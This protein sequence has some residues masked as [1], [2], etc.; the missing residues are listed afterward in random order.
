[1]YISIENVKHKLEYI[2]YPNYRRSESFYVVHCRNK[3][4]D[5]IKK[6]KH[7]PECGEDLTCAHD[8][9]I[10]ATDEYGNDYKICMLCGLRL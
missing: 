9:P 1:M 3:E 8:K 2:K 7:C 5:V 6:P 4:L 10:I